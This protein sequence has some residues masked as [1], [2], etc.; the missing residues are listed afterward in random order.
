VNNKVERKKGGIGGASGNGK[1]GYIASEIKEDMNHWLH[2]KQQ[3]QQQQQTISC[4]VLAQTTF[5]LTAA[6]K[7]LSKCH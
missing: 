2:L 4:R 3:Q 7:T 6:A 1:Y 5:I